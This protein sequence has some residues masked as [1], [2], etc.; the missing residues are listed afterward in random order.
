MKIYYGYG[1]PIE[2]TDEW[3]EILI[4]EDHDLENHERTETRRHSPHDLFELPSLFSL[5][6]EVALR[7]FRK[8]AVAA[9]S[10]ENQELYRLYHIE[11]IAA[12]EIAAITGTTVRAVNRRINRINDTL[13]KFYENNF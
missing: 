12:K 13:K 8:R 3:H 11:D 5:E 2:I 9:L 7:D 1:Q 6:S 4:A 10:P